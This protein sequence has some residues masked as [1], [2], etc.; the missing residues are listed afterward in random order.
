MR[1]QP[2]SC[3]S[4]LGLAATVAIGQGAVAMP[5]ASGPTVPAPDV[6]AP[7]LLRYGTVWTDADLV[8]VGGQLDP[9]AAL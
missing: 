7:S 5:V 6:Q 3:L 8:A 4:L 2:R 1:M 9:S